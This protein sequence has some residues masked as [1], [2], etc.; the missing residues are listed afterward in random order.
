MRFLR[1][2]AA[3]APALMLAACGGQ[4][5]PSDAPVVDGTLADTAIDDTAQMIDTTPGEPGVETSW[6]IDRDGRF[7]EA[8]YRNFTANRF[9]EWDRNADE[10]VELQ[11]FTERWQG[12][13]LKDGRGAFAEYDQN[14]DGVLS[15]AELSR[16]DMWTL[17]DEDRSGT[18]EPDEFTFY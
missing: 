11:E 10:R 18:L 5:E 6:D 9:G 2:A 17:W 12:Q 8:E 13:G 16:D 14:Q 15:P 1:F 4:A 7:N 3:A